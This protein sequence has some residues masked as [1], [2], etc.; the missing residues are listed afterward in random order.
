LPVS[1]HWFGAAGLG[2]TL[3]ADTCKNR[4]L[5]RTKRKTKKK[6]KLLAWTQDLDKHG[7]V[8]YQGRLTKKTAA[9][10]K[11][12]GSGRE[13]ALIKNLDLVKNRWDMLIRVTHQP[14]HGWGVSAERGSAHASGKGGPRGSLSGRGEKNTTY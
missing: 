10:K 6:Q 9:G 14:T 7:E 3:L 12:G 1:A 4:R 11:S 13:T 8:R 5:N 2:R